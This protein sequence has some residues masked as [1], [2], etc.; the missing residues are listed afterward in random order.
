MSA[1]FTSV[2]LSLHV[3]TGCETVSAFRCKEK[4][5]PLKALQLYSL[6][7]K[8]LAK[9]GES[10]SIGKDLLDEVEAFICAMYG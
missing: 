3:Y 6:F 8:T 2:F 1:I 5:K 9:L 10:W 4:P 7:I